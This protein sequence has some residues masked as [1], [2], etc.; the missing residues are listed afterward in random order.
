M[1]Q[2]G[3]WIISGCG[4]GTFCGRRVATIR[5]RQ[6]LHKLAHHRFWLRPDEFIN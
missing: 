2:T 6:A 3:C 1:L 4:L 5:F